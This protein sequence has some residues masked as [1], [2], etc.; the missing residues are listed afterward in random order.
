MS[1]SHPDKQ[2]LR[3]ESLARRAAILEG[4]RKKAAA[5]LAE[6]ALPFLDLPAPLAISG[7]YPFGD[8]LDI[9][10]LLRRL[11]ADGHTIG[12]P[13][14]RKGQPLTFRLWTPETRMVRGV[15][16]IPRPPDDAPEVTPSV[17]LVPLAAFDG[18]GYRIGYGGG[19]YDR[20]LSQLRASGPVTAV[21]VAFAEQQVERVP[22]E[23]HDEPLDWMLT[24]DG[25]YSLEQG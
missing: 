16:G 8:E 25:A 22:N 20:T 2:T 6:R 7:Y 10:P 23:P 4:T 9:L 21:G 17:L 15:L 1:V 24:P 5:A 12:L 11:I 3:R 14:T 19:F 13:V 18:R